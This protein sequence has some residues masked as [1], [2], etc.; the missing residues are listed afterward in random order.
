MKGFYLE[1]FGKYG[2]RT[3]LPIPQTPIEGI[4]VKVLTARTSPNFKPFLMGMF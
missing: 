4:K 2:I 3:D 1:K